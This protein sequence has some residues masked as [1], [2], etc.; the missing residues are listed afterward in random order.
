MTRWVVGTL[1]AL[2]GVALGWGWVQGADVLRLSQN[3]PGDSKPIILHA[4]EITTWTEG[5]YRVFLLKGMVLVE[6]GVVSARMKNG[7]AWVDQE[8][9]RKTGVLRLDLYA[10]GEVN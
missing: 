10:D 9:T 8:R 4:N 7:V 1:L 3:I 6:H 2:A 5:S